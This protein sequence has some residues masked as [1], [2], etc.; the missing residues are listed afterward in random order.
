MN[1]VTLLLILVFVGI[2][3]LGALVWI[4]DWYDA[5]KRRHP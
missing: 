3:I 2:V 5:R 4:S 1:S